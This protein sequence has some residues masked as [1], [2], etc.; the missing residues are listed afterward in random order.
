MDF[1]LDENEKRLEQEEKE[2]KVNWKPIMTSLGILSDINVFKEIVKGLEID[3]DLLG[4]LEEYL[5]EK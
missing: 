3:K 4:L 1:Y 5:D 2:N